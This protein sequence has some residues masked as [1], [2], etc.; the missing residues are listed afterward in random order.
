MITCCSAG[1]GSILFAIT[2]DSPELNVAPLGDQKQHRLSNEIII[3]APSVSSSK[4]RI[5]SKRPQ[6]ISFEEDENESIN[7]LKSLTP[8]KLSN[9]DVKPLDEYKP[10]ETAERTK[11]NTSDYVIIETND[12]IKINEIEIKYA[13]PESPTTIKM[14]SPIVAA[15]PDIFSY[16]EA[17]LT[18]V[19]IIDSISSNIATQ[20]SSASVSSSSS[21]STEKPLSST[22]LNESL[23]SSIISDE[24]STSSTVDVNSRITELEQ[25]CISLEQQVAALTM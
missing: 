7:V 8:P 3:A 1:L 19:P 17:D 12:L 14:C 13:E 9:A 15:Y 16:K 10:L 2:V 23:H 20:S 22:S 4:T 21:L 24:K 5:G 25:R 18:V 6:I 11:A